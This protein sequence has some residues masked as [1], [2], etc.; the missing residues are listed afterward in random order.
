ML[1]RSETGPSSHRLAAAR[2]RTI[3][4]RLRRL[5]PP[6][7]AGTTTVAGTGALVAWV[8]HQPGVS[9]AASTTTNRPVGSAPPAGP[10]GPDP[11]AREAQVVS[12]VQKQLSAEEAT[13]REL[14][15]RVAGLAA[16]PL[17]STSAN[18]STKQATPSV[19]AGAP[20]ASVNAP[21]GSGTGSWGTGSGAIPSTAGGAGSAGSPAPLPAL[22]PLPTIPSL[23]A[24]AASPAPTQ[25]AAPPATNATT[26][27][28]HAVP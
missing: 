6:L 12:A 16:N 17:S 15:V 1:D 8:S 24:P 23:P 7:L 19:G 2:R 26:G 18:R 21:T 3:G 9:A 13:L 28:S 14:Q 20:A 25:V 10:I 22:T 11:A 4:V 5:I 27:A